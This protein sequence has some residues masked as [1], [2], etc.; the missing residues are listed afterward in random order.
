[1]GEAGSTPQ[2]VLCPLS[3]SH[4]GHYICRV[5]HGANCTF[6]QWAHIGV[7]HSG[8][9]LICHVQPFIICS[10]MQG[11]SRA[12]YNIW[13]FQTA[14]VPAVCFQGQGVGCWSPFSLNHKCCRRVRACSWSAKQRAILLR[15]TSGTTTHYP[16]NNTMHVRSRWGRPRQWQRIL[17]ARESIRVTD[18]KNGLK[19]QIQ[20]EC[21]TPNNTTTWYMEEKHKKHKNI[22]EA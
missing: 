12:H 15:S 13:R 17:S 18:A 6:S 21:K 14:A 3:L 7:I 10:S 11:S 16:W 5:N 1:M 2:L 8:G 22:K 9:T 19:C 4:K 20:R